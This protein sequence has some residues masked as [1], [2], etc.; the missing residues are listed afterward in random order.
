[1]V[2]WMKSAAASISG[3]LRSGMAR[4]LETGG[5]AVAV[6]AFLAVG[7]EGVE[8]ALFMVGFAEADTRWPLAGLI[9]GVLIVIAIVYAMYAGAIRINLATFFKYTTVFLIVVAANILSY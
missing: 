3:E 4:A 2:L 9:V 5:L 1:M 6:L 8:T 7:R